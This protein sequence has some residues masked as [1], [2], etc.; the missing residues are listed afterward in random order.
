MF[1]LP[2]IHN[3]SLYM[4]KH[5]TNSKRDNLYNNWTKGLKSVKVIK[6]KDS[7]KKLSQLQEG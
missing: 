6:N 3:L 5:Q 4:R 2:K 7:L 1:F